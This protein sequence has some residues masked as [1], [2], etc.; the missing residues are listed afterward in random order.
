MRILIISNS[1]GFDRDLRDELEQRGKEVYLLDFQSLSLEYH[2]NIDMTYANVFLRFKTL[3]KLHMAFRIYFI[4]KLLRTMEFE[5]VNIHFSSWKYLFFLSA[6]KRF[7]MIITFYGSDFYRTSSFV[8][9]IQNIIY[10]K[11]DAF[12]FTN[13]M[14][15]DAFTQY[16]GNYE[17]KSHVCRFGLKALNYIDKNRLKPKEE[18]RRVL[19]YSESKTIVTCGHNATRA[20]QHRKIIDELVLLGNDVLRKMQF[21]FPMTYGDIRYREEIKDLLQKSGLDYVVLEEFLCEDDNAYV[22]LSSN[23]M[24]NVLQTDSFS[25]SMQEFLYAGNKVITG[26][27]LPYEVFDAAGIVYTKIDSIH[28]LVTTLK[29]ILD[30]PGEEKGAFENNRAI[31]SMLSSWSANIATWIQVYEKH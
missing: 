4:S 26:S 20:Q 3:P 28:Q 17:D 23:I 29:E 25:G 30:H 24:I 9:R 1:F 16:Y 2:D 21:V 22:K 13:P 27:W 7:R 11:A 5:L 31:V 19:G 8:K 10:K 15:K 12:T 14:T 18:M 6:L